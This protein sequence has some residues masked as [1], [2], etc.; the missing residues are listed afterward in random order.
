[1]LFMEYIKIIFFTFLIIRFLVGNVNFYL[2]VDFID[3]LFI[4]V[5]NIN[6]SFIENE[7]LS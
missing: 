3:V 2:Y 6:I 1:M 7:I 4:C 5:V